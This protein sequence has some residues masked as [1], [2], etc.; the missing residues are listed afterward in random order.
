MHLSIEVS[1]PCLPPPAA[2]STSSSSSRSSPVVPSILLPRV[3]VVESGGALS[4]TTLEDL[5]KTQVLKHPKRPKGLEG[6][7]A[8]KEQGVVGDHGRVVF[9]TRLVKAPGLPDVAS[10]TVTAPFSGASSTPVA[11]RGI[12][13]PA[14]PESST[15]VSLLR[16][17]GFVE[18]PTIE[19]WARSEWE[20]AVEAGEVSVV[21]KCD[22]HGM[23]VRPR[24]G[25]RSAASEKSEAI[26]QQ[27]SVDTIPQ[28]LT[29]ADHS[30]A[31]GQADGPA[32]EKQEQ[33]SSTARLHAEDRA[34]AALPVSEATHE[35]HLSHEQA[36]SRQEQ[37]GDERAD[38]K[39]TAEAMDIEAI[40]TDTEAGNAASAEAANTVGSSLV[41]DGTEGERS[42]KRTRVETEPKAEEPASLD[43]APEAAGATEPAL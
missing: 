9:A 13:Q 4:S 19:V 41:N 22:E 2:P 33:D 38:L 25:V 20:R 18:Y 24:V 31:A 5:L 12:Y 17:L 8:A 11:T 1:F 10:D 23:A 35:T 42:P 32:Q 3:A 39:R 7:L 21:G 28:E 40:A 30:V 37:E 6:W 43:V 26:E 16:G 27:A 14:H 34:G 36:S 29:E 15:L